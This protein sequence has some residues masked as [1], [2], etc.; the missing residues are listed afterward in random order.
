MAADLTPSVANADSAQTPIAP[1]E[2]IH[3]GSAALSVAIAP[4]AGGRIAQIR[5]DGVEWLVGHDDE[6]QAVI[7]WG[8]YPMLPWAGRIRHG[9]FGFDGRRYALPINLGAHAIHG[10]GLALP[11]QVDVHGPHEVELS[12]ALPQDERWPFGGR[13]HQ[14]IEVMEH[15]LRMQ[16]TVTAGKIGMPVTL[17]WHP[18]FRKPD[19]LQFVPERAYPRDDDGMACL[20]LIDPPPPPWDDCFINMRPVEMQRAG[21]RVRLTSDCNH[22]VV[23]DEPQHA[24]CIEPQSGPP[25]A[26]NLGLGQYLEPTASLSAWFL[27]EWL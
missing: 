11:W 27:L 9:Q 24:T 15:S 6:H 25:D 5:H 21:Q 2:L 1:G 3:I 10:V 22:W 18:W 23:Y 19:R 7:A 17:G 4:E 8:S 13:A 16:L 26:F 20:P 14:R 12:L